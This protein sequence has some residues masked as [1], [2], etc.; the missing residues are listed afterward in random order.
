MA[1]VA[2]GRKIWN[3]LG[4]KFVTRRSITGRVLPSSGWKELH[5][6][7]KTKAKAK[8]V[9]TLKRATDDQFDGVLRLVRAP[10]ARSAGLVTL[11]ESR[12]NAAD[13]AILAWRRSR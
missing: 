8:R 5:T 10:S 7:K 3:G 12:V 2:S 1:W 13:D 9:S 6:M 4:T 11:R